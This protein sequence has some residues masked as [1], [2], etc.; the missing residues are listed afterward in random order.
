LLGALPGEQAREIERRIFLEQEFHELVEAVETELIRDF[1]RGKLS[2]PMQEAFLARYQRTPELWERVTAMSAVMSAASS[3]APAARGSSWRSK[4][5][6]WFLPAPA[7]V[8]GATGLAVIGLCVAVWFGMR[9]QALQDSVA[10]ALRSRD[11]LA[12]ENRRLREEIAAMGS[13]RAPARVLAL[14]LMPG[15]TRSGSAHQRVARLS[16]EDELELTLHAPQ[17]LTPGSYRVTLEQGESGRVVYRS[18]GVETRA[19]Q[20]GA[21]V[22][23]IPAAGLETED[24]LVSLESRSGAGGY[25]TVETYWLRIV[26]AT[27]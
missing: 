26:A 2:A 15:V 9:N 21:V 20:P 10:R 16:G 5:A 12:G 19:G 13:T 7:V 3:L 25:D 24:Y 1:I 27:P 6:P 17:V 8:Y 14:A 23:R 11:A 18:A 22:A 4:L